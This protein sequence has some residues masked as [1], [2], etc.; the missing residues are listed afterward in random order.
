[1]GI[2]EGLTN[3]FT[4]IICAFN[5]QN[6][7]S[8]VIESLLAQN[9][10]EELVEEILIIDNNSTDRTADLVK[11]YEKDNKM[12]RYI[13]EE[14]QGLSNARLAGIKESRSPWI[15]FIDDDNILESDWIC[16]AY[17]YI[18]IT[19]NVGAFNGSVVPVFSESLTKREE[20][21]LEIVLESLAC[22]NIK[23]ETIDFKNN[24]HPYDM[25]FGAGLVIRKKPLDKLIK[26]GWLTLEGRKGDKLSSGEDSEMCLFVKSEG[27]CFGFNPKM[28][29]NHKISISRLEEDYLR[30]LVAGIS[31]SSY[32]LY[33][34]D[35]SKIKVLSLT[36]MKLI[37]RY[38]QYIIS[39]KYKRKF[40][41]LL[42]IE[43]Q[44]S[45]FKYISKN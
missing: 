13:F 4:L 25:P 45:K 15:V 8:E 32:E 7:I 2:E 17:N 42:S 9:K 12:I 31:R 33:E 26:N 11:I 27:Y 43:R 36:I 1:M 19:N 18:K 3:I 6:R 23:R 30:R 34:K 5:A 28:I 40:K 37:I 10:L 35:E 16:E 14:N 44:L 24:N 20:E 22:T 38:I 39:L 21:R 29:I 41:Y